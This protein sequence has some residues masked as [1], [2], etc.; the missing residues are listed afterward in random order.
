MI[1]VCG[2]HGVGKD[3]YCNNLKLKEGVNNYTASQ[4]INQSIP[5][6]QNQT[7]RIDQIEDRQ[8]ALL[9]AVN[10]ISTQEKDFILNAHLSLINEKGE[11]ERISLSVFQS[12]P[13]TEIHLVECS[14]AE[15]KKR[16][17]N[18]N[19]ILWDE[20]FIRVFMEEEKNCAI[21]LSKILKVPLHI[22]DTSFNNKRNIILP[23]APKYIT[24]ILSG[25]KKYEYRK[26]LCKN[27]IYRIYLYATTPVKGIVGEAEVI[28]KLEENPE[29][30]WDLTSSTAGIDKDF[31]YKYFS[32]SIKAGAYKLGGVKKYKNKILLN[33]IGI[34][35]AI[36]SFKYISDI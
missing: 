14:A 7:K 10:Q 33:S 15:I 31:F 18:R 22:V 6:R 27:E 17:Y 11:I 23:I 13:I 32:G 35:Y 19:A 24:K 3:Y 36:Q 29:R 26:K 5:L 1:I 21:E 25:Q 12:M 20:G 16:I 2:I 30:L 34:D 28:D 8:Y 9:K 4:L